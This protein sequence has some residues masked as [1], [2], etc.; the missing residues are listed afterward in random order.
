MSH[1]SVA[2]GH[3][4]IMPRYKHCSA[5]GTANSKA[6]SNGEAE[7]TR[8]SGVKVDVVPAGTANSKACSDGEAELTRLS[9]VKVDVV[10][11]G[12]AVAARPALQRA[13]RSAQPG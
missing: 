1:H 10:P 2:R 8:L 4:V 13:A 11:A 7:L 9:G 3:A 5:A 12:T 6:C